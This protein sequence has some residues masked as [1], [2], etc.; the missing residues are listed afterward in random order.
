M[1]HDRWAHLD[2]AFLLHALDDEDAAEFEAHTVECATCRARVEE[3][4][5][6]LPYLIGSDEGVL[7]PDAELTPPTTL[8]P[9]LLEEARRE[10]RR[11]RART[12]TGAVLGALV[13]AAAAV[14]AFAVLAGGHDLGTGP[15]GATASARAMA[16]LR[17]SPVQAT[18]ALQPTPWGTRITLRCH[19][20]RAG[21]PPGGYAYALVVRATDGTRHRL[22]TWNLLPGHD[23]TFTSGTALN[24]AEIDAVD[25][26]TTAGTPLLELSN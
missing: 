24:P 16:P 3:L 23:L 18:A 7:D 1:T 9:R 26:T 12:G 15:A 11:R 25:V 10:R 13:A 5:T 2:A 20:G 22:G 8:L 4:R 14:L 17:P 6:V 21:A 19:Y